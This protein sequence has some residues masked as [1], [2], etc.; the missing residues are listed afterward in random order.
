MS[1]HEH[2]VRTRR[3]RASGQH[4]RELALAGG[5]VAAAAGQ[6]HGMGGI[7]DHRETEPEQDGNRTHVRDQVV[8][9]KCRAA[10][11]DEN[12][13]TTRSNR[14][15]DHLSHLR[16]RQELAFLQVDDP[17][18]QHRRLEQIGLAAKKGR[19]LQ[20]IDRLPGDGGLGF[21]VHVRQHGQGEFLADSGQY[22]QSFLEAGPA[23]G[24]ARRAVGLVIA[25]LENAGD[26]E[27]MARFL[28]RRRHPAAQFLALDDA[29]TGD[30]D[31]PARR[32]QRFPE[33]VGWSRHR[34]VLPMARS[35]V[36]GSRPAMCFEC[37]DTG[38]PA[39]AL[40]LV[41][42]NCVLHI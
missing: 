19:D 7:E 34:A 5:F 20:D 41:L 16:R 25:G 42:T 18:G 31:K 39:C 29:R 8:V 26:A 17:A 15:L 28:E 6:L 37:L 24:S 23:K 33:S 30:Q 1:F 36:N 13:L 38:R 3:D 21:R 27:S 32:A 14:F 10:L 35:N 12:L 9:T 2:A 40:G 4:R 22:F 11:G